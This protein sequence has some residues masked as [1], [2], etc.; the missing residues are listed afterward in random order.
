MACLSMMNYWVIWILLSCISVDTIFATPR[1]WSHLT[2]IFNCLELTLDL[3]RW[4]GCC[5][6]GH[7]MWSSSLLPPPPPHPLS[8]H[9]VWLARMTPWWEGWGYWGAKLDGWDPCWNQLVEH[10]TLIIEKPTGFIVNMQLTN[11]TLCAMDGVESVKARGGG[12]FSE[13]K[14]DFLLF[15]KEFFTYLVL[16]PPQLN[17]SWLWCVQ[18]ALSH[19]SHPFTPSTWTGR[20]G[21]LCF[22]VLEP[23]SVELLPEH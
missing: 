21:Y 19:P 14:V 11:C 18:D 23:E 9:T 3:G 2:W 20:L 16:F 22:S 7:G 13:R 15:I 10:W 6:Y 8:S 1:L 4:E 12:F 5:A 17:N